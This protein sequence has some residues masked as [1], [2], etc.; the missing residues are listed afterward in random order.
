M[1]KETKK[2]PANIRFK[3]LIKED[4][5][6]GCQACIVFCPVDCID[7]VK[8]PFFATVRVDL[9]RCIGCRLCAKYCPWDTIDMISTEEAYK[10]QAAYALRE[11]P[12]F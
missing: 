5:C 10:R 9:D 4:G 1:N 8:G 7:L 2:A 11:H 3:A 6:S 12:Q